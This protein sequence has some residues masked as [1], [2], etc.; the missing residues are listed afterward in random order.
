MRELRVLLSHS[1]VPADPDEIFDPILPSQL[2]PVRGIHAMQPEARLALAVLEDAIMTVRASAGV[3]APRS[4]R[5]VAETWAWIG[6]DDT[7]RAFAFVSVCEHL[8]LDPAS[9]RAGVRRWCRARVL[10]TRPLRRTAVVNGRAPRTRITSRRF[11]RDLRCAPP[12]VSR[13]DRDRR[14]S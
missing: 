1:P 9:L 14:A 4:R 11:A 8:G 10:D 6:S 7:T 3:H 2:D 12:G 13:R 5:L